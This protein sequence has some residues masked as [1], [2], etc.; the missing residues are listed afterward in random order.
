MDDAALSA[1]GVVLKAAC[2]EKE[3]TR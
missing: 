1:L 3:R 2:D